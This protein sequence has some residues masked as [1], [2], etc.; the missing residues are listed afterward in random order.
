MTKTPQTFTGS[1]AEA[2]DKAKQLLEPIFVPAP[3]YTDD[4]GWSLMNQFL[5]VMS[6]EGQVNYSVQ[7]PGVIKAW[8]RHAKQ[9]DFWM[10]LS[11][12]IKAGV[13]RESDNAT[14]SIV[15]GEKRPG[16]LV[17]PPPLWHGAATVGHVPAGLL[18]YVTHAFDLANPDEERRSFDIPIEFSWTVQHR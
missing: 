17:I 1:I 9:T 5:G 3:V 10:C 4:R 15:I 18:Y 8:H 2:F 6:P 13:H 14:W 12:H 11:G 7:Y 16:T